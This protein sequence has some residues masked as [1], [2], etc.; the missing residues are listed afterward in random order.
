MA[1][2]LSLSIPINLLLS[3]IPVNKCIVYIICT[4]S[5]NISL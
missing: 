2:L 3:L 4:L 1:G 5:E